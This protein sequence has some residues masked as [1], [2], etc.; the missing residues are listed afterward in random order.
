ME[1]RVLDICDKETSDKEVQVCYY[2]TTVKRDVASA[3]KNG[4][5]F[6]RICEK[7]AQKDGDICH[8]K[9]RKCSNL[10]QL[11]LP[12]LTQTAKATDW[13]EVDPSSLKVKDLKALLKEVGEDCKGCVEKADFAKKVDEIKAKKLKGEL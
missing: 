2:M 1:Q 9:Y 4:L 6:D 13:N 5:P 3:I 7:L 12:P 10:C 11:Y 8:V